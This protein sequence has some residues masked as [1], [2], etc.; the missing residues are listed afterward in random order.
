MAVESMGVAA[1]LNN[2]TEGLLQN[3]TGNKNSDLVEARDENGDVADAS[4]YN[5]YDEVTADWI[6][7]SG[8]TDTA[9]EIGDSVTVTGDF[10]GT[11]SVI[12]CSKAETNVDYPRWNMTL[13]KYNTNVVVPELT[14]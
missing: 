1:T 6:P 2:V 7:D 9:P 12:N 5:E 4:I 3:L 11:Y 8:V 13:R 10:A 14:D